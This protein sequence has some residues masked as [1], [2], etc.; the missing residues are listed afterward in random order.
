MKSE[1]K[2]VVTSPLEFQ[3]TKFHYFP[4]HYYLNINCSLIILHVPRY[5]IC[6]S[7]LCVDLRQCVQIIFSYFWPWRSLQGVIQALRSSLHSKL[8]FRRTG[9]LFRFQTFPCK[10]MAAAPAS[11]FAFALLRFWPVSAW[12]HPSSEVLLLLRLVSLLIGKSFIKKNKN[13]LLRAV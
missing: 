10:I 9:L 8:N 3:Q 2:A 5:S 6:T 11:L 7:S 12:F 13:G 1:V 4:H